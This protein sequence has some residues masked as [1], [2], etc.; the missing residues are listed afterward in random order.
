M[1]PKAA[2]ARL[3]ALV[4]SAQLDLA[5]LDVRTFPFADLG[6]ALD[7][8]ASMKGL[9]LVALTMNGGS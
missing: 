1:Y 4:E 7:K 5:A 6:R 3:A 8:A 2:P 9:D